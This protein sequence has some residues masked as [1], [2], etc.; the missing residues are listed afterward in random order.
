M[1]DFS[2]TE[3]AGAELLGAFHYDMSSWRDE[4]SGEIRHTLYFQ[5]EKE[6]ADALSILRVRTTE[7]EKYGIRL[8]SFQS[9]TLKKEDWAQSWKIHFKTMEISPRLVI[10]PSWESVEERPGRIV[11]T[12]DP[13]MSFGTGQHATTRFCLEAIDKFA[14]TGG[15]PLSFLDAGSGSGILSIAAFKLGFCPVT[16]FDID[17]DSIPVARENA[18][19]NGIA[20]DGISFE[21]ASLDSFRPG[22]RFDVAAANILSHVLIAGRDKLL[23]LV[24]PDGILILA[25]IL[26]S[27]YPA[28]RERFKHAGCEEL[29]T[30]GEKEWRGGVFRT[31]GTVRI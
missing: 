22:R 10:K 1:R 2:E 21:T 11:L 26:D 20:E 3:G 31:P 15:T 18:E 25:G 7:W 8:D 17:P 5:T 27:E 9:L 13:G 19:V 28:I 12:L 23:S 14:G 24:K 16:A 6:A 4:E 29:F 30:R